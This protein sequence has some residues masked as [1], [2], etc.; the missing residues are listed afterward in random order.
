[1][2]TDL[3]TKI[4]EV[5]G[6][7]D[8]GILADWMKEQVAATTVR[9]DLLKEGE[10]REQ[11]EHFLNLIRVAA[12]ANNLMDIQGPTWAPLREMLGELSRSRAIQ[13]FTSSETATFVLSFKQPLFTRLRRSHDNLDGLAE[14]LWKATALLDKL[15]LY[16]TEAFIKSREDIIGRQAKEMFELSSPVVELWQGILGLPIIGT[17]DSKRTQ[18][19]METL[20]ERIA[21][22]QAQFAI[23]DITGVPT[24]DTQTAQNLLKTVNATRLMGAE[25]IISGVRPQIAQTM[26]HLGVNLA[27]VITKSTLAGALAV[28]FKQRS[29]AVMPTAALVRN[30]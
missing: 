29:L 14:D 30:G 17:L 6:S 28:A 19:V 7:Q 26:V 27:G 13:G 21:Q 3:T 24:V 9:P 22:T 15:G 12:R 18:L 5:L 20:L 2:S 11:S 10:L 16:T 25:C 23:I 8:T 4:P 1:M